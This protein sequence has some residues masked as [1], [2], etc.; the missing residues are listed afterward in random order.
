[1]INFKSCQRCHGDVVV[2]EWLGQKEATCLQ[3]GYRRDV[4]SV[5]PSPIARTATSG[6]WPRAA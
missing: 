4:P 6:R 2:E 5:A 1:M 3:C